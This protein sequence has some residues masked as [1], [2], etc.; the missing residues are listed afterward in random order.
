MKI[1]ITGIAGFI[2]S[3][4]AHK[5]IASGHEV[6]GIDDLSWGFEEDVPKECM[7][8]EIDLL[9]IPVWIQGTLRRFYD[10]DHIF[11]DID[12]VIHCAAS[13]EVMESISSPVGDLRTNTEGTINVLDA[14]AQYEINNIINF[15]SACVYGPGNLDDKLLIG[16]ESAT[17]DSPQWP[18]GASKL[19]AEIY[20]NLYHQTDGF[21][22]INLR[23]GIVCGPGEWFGRALTIFLRRAMKGE[24]IV[25]FVDPGYHEGKPFRTP[26]RD[27][28][29]V[30]DVVQQTE[31]C[32]RLLEKA[33]KPFIETFNAS[34][35]LA[36]NIAEVAGMVAKKLEAKIVYEEVEEGKRSQLVKGRIRIPN[37]MKQMALSMYHATYSL[38]FSPSRSLD[39]IIDDEISWLRQG[40]LERWEE[41]DMKV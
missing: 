6:R 15:S 13:L 17:V 32:I 3:R 4:L 37:E 41:C 36:Y 21:N 10:P 40:G 11:K 33:D 9:E 31:A 14:M 22:V 29:H 39:T 12:L 1:L 27:F 19:S 8:A 35:R 7:L 26:V 38:G 30:D 2:G 24:D 20:C 16:E 18:Y 23:P 28:V 34:G 5:L 25:V